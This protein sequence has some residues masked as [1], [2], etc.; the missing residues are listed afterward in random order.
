MEIPESITDVGAAYLQ[1][2]RNV[3]PFSALATAVL[4]V[5]LSITRSANDVTDG[6][7]WLMAATTPISS[8]LKVDGGLWANLHILDVPIALGCSGLGLLFSG[9]FRRI[10]F[11]ALTTSKKFKTLEKSQS[12]ID[13]QDNV[14]P[15]MQIEWINKQIS[16]SL[17]SLKRKDS[18]AEI[19]CG[20]AV[21]SLYYGK[22]DVLLDSTILLLALLA[23]YICVQSSAKDYISK[24]YPF[25]LIK[26]N[27]IGFKYIEPKR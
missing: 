22:V 9:I 3:V 18:C 11:W 16:K 2:V 25:V 13:S 27:L 12:K 1:D 4:A 7:L 6:G 17:P 23:S 14:S 20:I 21:I 26:A 24:V 8:L 15:E 10:V 19:F 5:G